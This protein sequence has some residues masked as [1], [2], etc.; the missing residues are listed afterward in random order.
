MSVY[1]KR[2]LN[3]VRFEPKTIQMWISF[4]INKWLKMQWNIK[5]FYCWHKIFF[6]SI[7]LMISKD[8]M[9]ARDGET[10]RRLNAICLSLHLSSC[11][12]VWI[13]IFSCLAFQTDICVILI[14][15]TPYKFIV[16]FLKVYVF[17]RYSWFC[18]SISKCHYSKCQSTHTNAPT[19]EI[20]L[21]DRSPSK[22]AADGLHWPSLPSLNRRWLSSHLF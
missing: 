13:V 1:Y 20:E 18:A 22:I 17:P 14:V 4:F 9:R 21:C 19:K 8:M 6:S 10:K 2:A 7:Y 3:W 12:L 16:R 11:L 15:I 5:C